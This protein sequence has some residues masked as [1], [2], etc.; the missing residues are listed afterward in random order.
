MRN[1]SRASEN[2]VKTE[3]ST[4]SMQITSLKNDG[5]GRCATLVS[6]LRRGANRLV[7]GS[8]HLEGNPMVRLLA[9]PP[10]KTFSEFA[11]LISNRTTHIV[12][13]KLYQNG[14]ILRRSVFCHCYRSRNRSSSPREAAC[15]FS[16]ATPTCRRVF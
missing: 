14:D 6:E 3:M 15:C 1:A 9:R 11:L 10:L 2:E 7:R 13:A 8:M 12:D 5:D 4:K 16:S